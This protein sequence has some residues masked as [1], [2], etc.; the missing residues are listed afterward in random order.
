M[1]PEGNI[2]ESTQGLERGMSELEMAAQGGWHMSTLKVS[3]EGDSGHVPSPGKRPHA[4]CT[5]EC[6]YCAG[7]FRDTGETGLVRASTPEREFVCI[8]KIRFLRYPEP[9]VGDGR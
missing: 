3:N 9:I 2:N 4:G 1:G 6:S 7:A 8:A 5:T